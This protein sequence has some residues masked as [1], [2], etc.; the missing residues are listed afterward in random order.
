MPEL[1]EVE[2]VRRGL[3]PYVRGATVAEVRILHPRVSRRQ[4]GGATEL[5]TRLLGCRV[6]GLQRRGKYLWLNLDS[7]E[8]L[9]LHLGM[10][11]QIRVFE[12]PVADDP[13]VRAWFRL[14]ERWIAFR[15]MRTFGWMMLAPVG[16]GGLPAPVQ[17]IAADP[18][19][20][21]SDSAA[22]T[23]NL[24]ATS[25]SIKRILLDQEVI[26]GIGNIYADEA[27]WRSRIHFETP[28]DTL[29]EAAALGLIGDARDVL[30]EAL[31]AGGT[32]FDALYVGVSGQQ[33]WF[34][35][36]LSVYGR[37]GEACERCGGPISRV[38]FTNRSSYLCPACQ[39]RPEG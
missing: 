2:T 12:E 6:E 13:H 26:S 35:R 28:G 39:Q 32:S 22:V 11:G 8:A 23:R 16:P 37:E 14:E 5:R 21:E 29:S 25:R 19:S 4:P 38:A 9:V 36:H 24:T 20:P 30:A 15:D 1:P 31:D 33:G 34:Q 10:S 3:D 7:G 17:H 18:L 27:L